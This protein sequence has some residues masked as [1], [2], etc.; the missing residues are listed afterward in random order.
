M[1]YILTVFV[2]FLVL[3]I[4]L[5]LCQPHDDSDPPDGGFSG[6]TPHTDALTGCQYLSRQWGGITPRMDGHGR[7]VGC[8]AQ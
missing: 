8:R 3:S 2:L 6:L 5:T 4:G 7:Q 1:K